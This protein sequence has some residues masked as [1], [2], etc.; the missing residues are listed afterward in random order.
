MKKNTNSLLL[1]ELTAISPIDGR[2]RGSTEELA[3]YCSEYALIK[4]RFEI[5]GAYL[6]ALSR[7]GFVRKLSEQERKKL[8]HISSEVNQETALKVKKIELETRHDVKAVERAF[9]N[10]VKG[11]SMEDL[12]EMIHFGLTLLFH[13]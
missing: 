12:T 11:T 5:E 6:L 7:A 8:S 10:M 4:T 1:N 9:R 13:S 2:Y 3:S